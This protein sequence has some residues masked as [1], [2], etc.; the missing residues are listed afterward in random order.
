MAPPVLIVQV[1]RGDRVVL[2]ALELSPG[3]VKL[4]SLPILI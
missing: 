4:L 2:G 1:P 3:E